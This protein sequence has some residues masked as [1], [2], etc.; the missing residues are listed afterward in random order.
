MDLNKKELMNLWRNTF[1][2]SEA[3]IK[4]FFDRVYKKELVQ[5]I[6]KEGKIV[7]ALYI[8]PYTLNFYGKKINTGYIYAASTIPT[9]RGKGN[10]H[11]LIQQAFDV[12]KSKNIS[13]CVT[14]PATSSLFHFYKELGFTE[15]FDYS[16]ECYTRP[17][18]PEEEEKLILVVPPTVPSIE[19]L[20]N[21]FDRKQRERS[22]YLLHTFEDF[23][24]ILRDI[25][26]SGGQMLTALNLLEEP[27]G[28]IFFHPNTDHIYVNELFY[29]HI[30][31]KELLLQE[32]TVQYNVQKAL[33][34]T[35]AI[36]RQAI[37]LGLAHIINK[38]Y[39]IHNW[40]CTHGNSPLNEDK[41]KAMD[42]STLTHLLLGYN[43]REAYMSLMFD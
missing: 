40:I 29:D 14:I 37:P 6:K 7:S 33:Y 5:F 12:M 23:I 38:E 42:H 11:Q 19:T 39:L 28:M 26:L 30:R 16:L 43:S 27:V 8:L 18:E 3:F 1:K 24:T 2:D 25:Q 35:P 4:L 41:I 21:Y 22:C 13:L 9:E 20:Y 34:R 10:I 36:G 32:A 31:I 15:A 17:S